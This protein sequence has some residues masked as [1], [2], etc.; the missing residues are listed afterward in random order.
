[1]MHILKKKETEF[2][3]S[4]MKQVTKIKIQILSWCHLMVYGAKLMGI[5]CSTLWDY[6][7]PSA[8]FD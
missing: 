4:D 7:S 8:F 2:T 3:V 6:D 1:M 5:I